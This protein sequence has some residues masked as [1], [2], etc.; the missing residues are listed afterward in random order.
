[1]FG[2]ECSGVE[3]A[4][5]ADDGGLPPPVSGAEAE[6]LVSA[7]GLEPGTPTLKGFSKLK[8]INDDVHISK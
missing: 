4:Q 6:P 2:D 7:P 5:G 8:E 3:R 1:V